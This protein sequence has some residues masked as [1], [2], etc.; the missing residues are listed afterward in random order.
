M[1]AE[2]HETCVIAFWGVAQEIED[3]IVIEEEVAG[4]APLGPNDVW[5]LNGI[6]TEEDGLFMLVR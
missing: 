4:V 6:S 2:E 5:A 1:V 3:G